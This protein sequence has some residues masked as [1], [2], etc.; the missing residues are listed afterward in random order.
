MPAP[1]HTLTFANNHASLIL[2]A[3]VEHDLN[4]L[5]KIIENA[6]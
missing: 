4:L 6:K 5:L 2:L 3:L 1:D